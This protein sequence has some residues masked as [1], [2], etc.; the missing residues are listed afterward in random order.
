LQA[1]CVDGRNTWYCNSW[2]GTKSISDGTLT[3]IWVSQ[4]MSGGYGGLTSDAT[5]STTSQGSVN[6]SDA[7][8]WLPSVTCNNYTWKPNSGAWYFNPGQHH[9]CTQTPQAPSVNIATQIGC[10]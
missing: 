10:Y 1:S 3:N 4:W 2:N 7:T 9:L 8:S 5:P 6:F